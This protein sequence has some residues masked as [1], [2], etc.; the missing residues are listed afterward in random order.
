MTHLQFKTNFCE[1][2]IVDWRGRVD[3][4]V[5]ALSVEREIHVPWWTHIWQQCVLCHAKQCHFFC[6]KCGNNMRYP[7]LPFVLFPS[8]QF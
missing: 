3:D 4:V 5:E 6:S 8:P 7:I 1:I 2:L